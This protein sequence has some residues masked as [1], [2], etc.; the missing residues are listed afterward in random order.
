MEHPTIP[1]VLCGL[2]EVVF[3]RGYRGG[4]PFLSAESA[5]EP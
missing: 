3:V 4:P 1:S 2:W 5:A